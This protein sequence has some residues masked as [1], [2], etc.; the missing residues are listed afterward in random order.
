M[1]N[2]GSSHR[3][4]R[5]ADVVDSHG[6]LHAGFKLGKQRVAAV[7]MIKCVPYGGFTIGQT[8]DWRV[9]IKYPGSDRQV[10]ENKVL[11]GG[12]DSRRA[13]AIDIDNG[14]VGLAS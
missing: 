2:V 6:H 4:E 12:N 3:W 1:T 14:F 9:R 10:F 8:L 5:Q 7:R 13:V 11:S